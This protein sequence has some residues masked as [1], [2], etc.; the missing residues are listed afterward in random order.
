MT[1]SFSTLHSLALEAHTLDPTLGVTL[2]VTLSL[3]K[4]YLLLY[5][6]YRYITIKY[7]CSLEIILSVLIVH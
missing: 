1:F 2:L 7:N 6:G 5:N 4:E 3:P